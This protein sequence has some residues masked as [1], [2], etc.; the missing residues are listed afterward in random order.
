MSTSGDRE[1]RPVENLP[2]LP[3]MAAIVR[4]EHGDPGRHVASPEPAHRRGHGDAR[5]I[6]AVRGTPLLIW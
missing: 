5:R 2:S 1:D 3:L 4:G 6:E